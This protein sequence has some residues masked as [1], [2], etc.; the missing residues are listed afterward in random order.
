MLSRRV[1][2]KPKKSGRNL[3]F[4]E[5]CFL[6]FLVA[7]KYLASGCSMSSLS[8]YL[9]DMPIE[10]LYARLFEKQLPDIELVSQRGSASSA[11]E[12]VVAST[13]RSKIEFTRK[14]YF[15]IKVTDGLNL[16]VEQGKFSEEDLTEMTTYLERFASS[17]K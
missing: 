6:H 11:A 4:D 3:I 7:R 17:H 9:L 10:D 8:E 16:L 14:S 13:P 15:N 1:I 12:S 2:Q 5:A